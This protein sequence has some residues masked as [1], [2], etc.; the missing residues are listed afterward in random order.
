MCRR[1]IELECAKNKNRP[2]LNYQTHVTSK[3]WGDGWRTENQISNPLDQKLD[4]QAIK[5]N[6]PNCNVYYSVYFNEKE[7]WS[8]EVANDQQAGTTGKSK[9]IMGIKIR[10]DETGAKKFDILYRMHKF[11][12]KWTSWAKNGEELISDG[13]K[14][15]AIQ[16]KLQPK[17]KTA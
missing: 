6:F 9:P 7:G 15:N 10:L 17:F 3:G 5:I 16:I 12:G 1:I 14:L 8:A 11:N 2:L 13:I 4:I